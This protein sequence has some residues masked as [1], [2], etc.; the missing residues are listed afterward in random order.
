[1][2]GQLHSD[3]IRPQSARKLIKLFCEHRAEVSQPQT[4]V[5]YLREK[6]YTKVTGHNTDYKLE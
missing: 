4:M 5:D 1:M 3:Q 6:R 2:G